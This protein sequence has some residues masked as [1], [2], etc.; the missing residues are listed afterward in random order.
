MSKKDVSIFPYKTETTFFSTCHQILFQNKK[1]LLKVRKKWKWKL[2]YAVCIT[3]ERHILFFFLILQK[4]IMTL[5]C[6]KY[7]AYMHI[8]IY[9]IINFNFTRLIKQ[10][11]FYCMQD[12]WKRKKK[13]IYDFIKQIYHFWCKTCYINH[14]MRKAFIIS[15]WIK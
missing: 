1:I 7:F 2:I 12:T 8:Y 6:Q 11:Q 3:N 13:S 10:L 9:L 4:W 15:G 14:R 5:L